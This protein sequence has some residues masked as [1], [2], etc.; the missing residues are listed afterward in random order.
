VNCQTGG[1]TWEDGACPC[2]SAGVA[3]VMDCGRQRRWRGMERPL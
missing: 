3:S 2:E 1:V